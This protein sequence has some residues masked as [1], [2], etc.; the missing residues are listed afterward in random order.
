VKKCRSEEVEGGRS[1]KPKSG[2]VGK[3]KTKKWET[4]K[5]KTKKWTSGKTEN[6]KSGKG[7]LAPAASRQDQLHWAP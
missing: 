5:S 3:W 4:R 2:E 1:Q 6:Q 7:E